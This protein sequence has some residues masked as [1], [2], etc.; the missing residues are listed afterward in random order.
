ML[1]CLQLMNFFTYENIS[2]QITFHV[3]LPLPNTFLV[4]SFG[5]WS[6]V[7]LETLN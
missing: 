7:N 5:S 2:M 1:V 3:T 6:K 4:H